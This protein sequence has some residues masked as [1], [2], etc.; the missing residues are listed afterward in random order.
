MT[1]YLQRIHV[2][3]VLTHAVLSV[4]HA[5]SP[6]DIAAL[7]PV[8]IFHPA[9][10]RYVLPVSVDDVMSSHNGPDTDTGF[11]PGGTAKLRPRGGG[12]RSLLSPI[13]LLISAMPLSLGQIATEH[14][15]S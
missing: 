10:I 1:L 4:T 15:H 5:A 9:A 2:R 8:F 12:G 7:R 3:H 11:S 13:A 14:Y 6:H